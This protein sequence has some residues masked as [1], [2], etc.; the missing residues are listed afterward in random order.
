MAQTKSFYLKAAL[1]SLTFIIFSGTAA[2]ATSSG[3]VSFW[4]E[5]DDLFVPERP[6]PQ[7]PPERI[8]DDVL[9]NREIPDVRSLH[10]PEG[11]MIRIIVPDPN[12]SQM[13][14]LGT[15]T[16][17][18]HR[19]SDGGNSWTS[20]NQGLTQIDYRALGVHPTESNILLAA[21]FAAG[22]VRSEDGGQTWS[23]SH[24]GT[25]TGTGI[26]F[27][28][29]PIDPSRVYY[30]SS[31][32]VYVSP[33]TGKTWT[34]IPIP[35]AS[36]RNAIAIDPLD[37]TRLLIGTNS[38]LFIS[39][40]SGSSWAAHN[41]DFSAVSSLTIREIIFDAQ[42]PLLAYLAFWAHNTGVDGGVY[43]S[44]DG[45]LTWASA[46]SGIPAYSNFDYHS[47]TCDPFNE[48]HAYA[49]LYSHGVYKTTNGGLTWSSSSNGIPT[50]ARQCWAVAASQNPGGVYAGN[51]VP[52]GGFYNS[53]DAGASWSRSTTGLYA[54]DINALE[55]DPFVPLR[56]CVGIRG[57]IH[58]WTG[59]TGRPGD[60]REAVW[61]RICP[62]L[63]TQGMPD[64]VYNTL[65]I[66]PS[67]LYISHSLR[68]HSGV[69]VSTDDGVSTQERPN[70]SHWT[71]SI[72]VNPID[73]TDLYTGTFYDGIFESTDAGVTWS[74][75]N[76]G[77]TN[78][79]CNK[80]IAAHDNPLRIFAGMS[81]GLYRSTNGGA[82][83]NILNNGLPAAGIADID[84]DPLNSSRMFTVVGA[85]V[86]SPC[87]YR[88]EDGGDLWEPLDIPGIGLAV[89]E[90][91]EKLDI[92]AADPD[93]IAG[94]DPFDQVLV[95]NPNTPH[96]VYSE[97]GGD[98]WTLLADDRAYVDMTILPTAD[99]VILAGAVGEGIL[100]IY[101]PS[102]E[103]SDV[104]DGDPDLH[105]GRQVSLRSFP[106]PFHRS[107]SLRYELP[108]QTQVRLSIYDLTGRL[109]RQFNNLG[110][111]EA[112]RYQV[113]WDG[114]DDT[115]RELGSGVY[116]LRLKT[117][118]D[119]AT[120]RVLRTR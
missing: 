43:R 76:V 37:P 60:G 8:F 40:D 35:G 31:S 100:Q 2:H 120:Q 20:L 58:R 64:R 5:A 6:T 55:S 78:P 107:T 46:N 105:P 75:R 94:I 47:M 21:G 98:H 65:A 15:F 44:T 95:G 109:V 93:F 30:L 9:F 88:S 19:S 115:G 23:W 12:D 71:K 79:A 116:F 14:Y 17:G 87:V 91:I 53:T 48:G 89:F 110:E 24:T 85:A 41:D 113:V 54:E 101:G 67:G 77:L 80:I 25:D 106:N 29:D 3:S 82:N 11:A 36:A 119:E 90:F 104:E 22:P 32:R 108:A 16:G 66:F 27:A 10:G 61:E 111:L 114:T 63:P 118:F 81:D 18:I 62:D 70:E 97:D 33:D 56:F 50:G 96:I 92:S 72:G 1:L 103:S 112:G 51:A 13:I 102:L 26:E 69:Y 68:L 39:T 57:G 4:P 117:R 73:P 59:D 45:G 99:P 42:D 38:G 84:I 49:A 74:E 83:W 86:G 7:M 34:E 52:A 28:F